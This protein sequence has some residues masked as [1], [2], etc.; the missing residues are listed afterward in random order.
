MGLR[1]TGPFKSNLKTKTDD[2]V[3]IQ[4]CRAGENLIGL[5]LSPM[6]DSPMLQ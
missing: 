4:Q 3:E 1:Q 2:Y 6:T 5:R